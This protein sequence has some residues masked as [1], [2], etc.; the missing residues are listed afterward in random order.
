MVNQMEEVDKKQIIEG[1]DEWIEVA[2]RDWV[3]GS[4]FLTDNDKGKLVGILFK[5]LKELEGGK[6]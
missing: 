4:A 2:L 3:V 1:S 6:K 5:R